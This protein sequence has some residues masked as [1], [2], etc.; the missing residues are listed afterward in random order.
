MKKITNNCGSQHKPFRSVFIVLIVVSLFSATI[1]T[2]HLK[3]D[4]NTSMDKTFTQQA[5][6]QG[7]VTDNGQAAMESETTNGQAAIQSE[8]TNGQAAMESKSPLTSGNNVQKFFPGKT[9]P[10]ISNPNIADNPVVADPSPGETTGRF[11][12]DDQGGF[13]ECTGGS[14]S[15]DCAA[16]KPFCKDDLQCGADK[17]TCARAAK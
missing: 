3:T 10:Q 15:T 12:C 1:S 4:I 2:M 11:S 16:I 5:F 6:A 8:T 7:N 9:G 14:G 17:C 13:C